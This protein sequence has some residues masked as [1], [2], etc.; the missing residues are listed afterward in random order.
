MAQLQERGGKQSTDAAVRES[1]LNSP[2]ALKRANGDYS[3]ES[4][5]TDAMIVAVENAPGGQLGQK[6]K[7]S[8]INK[9]VKK[10]LDISTDQQ[11]RMDKIRANLGTYKPTK[12]SAAAS[13]A[14]AAARA[15]KYDRKRDKF[16]EEKHRDVRNQEAAIRSAAGGI[17]GDVM[18]QVKLK[19]SYVD[20]T[21]GEILD[22]KDVLANAGAEDL[23]AEQKDTAKEKAARDAKV[24]AYLAKSGG[25]GLAPEATRKNMTELRAKLAEMKKSKAED[26]AEFDAVLKDTLDNGKEVI[27]ADKA[28][29][30]AKEKASNDADRAEFDQALRDVNEILSDK[31]TEEYYAEYAVEGAMK[32]MENVAEKQ[33]AAIDEELDEAAHTIENATQAQVDAETKALLDGLKIKKQSL[34]SRFGNGFKGAWKAVT[35]FFKKKETVQSAAETPTAAAGNTVPRTANFRIS[36]EHAG[37]SGSVRVRATAG[38]PRAVAEARAA[39]A[40]RPANVHS[41]EAMRLNLEELLPE[42]TPREDELDEQIKLEPRLAQYALESDEE[43]DNQIAREKKK[44]GVKSAVMIEGLQNIKEIHK[45]DNERAQTAATLQREFAKLDK[46]ALPDA[47]TSLLSLDGETLNGMKE[48]LTESLGNEYKKYARTDRY[49][50]KLV[51]G[52]INDIEAKMARGEDVDFKLHDA[53]LTA[54]KLHVVNREMKRREVSSYDS[55]DFVKREGF[56]NLSI[57]QILKTLNSWKEG[58][59]KGSDGAPVS[60]AKT[61]E[62]IKELNMILDTLAE[63]GVRGPLNEA[64]LLSGIT[65]TGGLRD[66]LKKIVNDRFPVDEKK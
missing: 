45:L 55:F 54:R 11:A 23:K 56:K 15:D 57:E 58:D 35:G 31:A 42:L 64:M 19:D 30:A 16:Y 1:L 6:E 7:T 25:K 29:E 34:L 36:G 51:E 47:D 2:E 60:L 20:Q 61:I 13:E 43:I 12:K 18:S 37:V 32:E 46:I 21:T 10:V 4:E 49:T 38:E 26:K 8:L 41:I 50:P 48:S 14:E 39:E 66:Q 3:V 44:R 33:S 22:A 63:R 40:A 17:K 65:R 27:A 28:V 5:V 52:L 53:L 59:L 62:S 9:A 24:D